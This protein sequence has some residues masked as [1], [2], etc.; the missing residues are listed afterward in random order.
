VNFVDRLQGQA[1]LYRGD[2]AGRVGLCVRV[3][4]GDWR[5]RMPAHRCVAP[6]THAQW[7]PMP[8][9]ESLVDLSA[10][11]LELPDPGLAVMLYGSRARGDSTRDSDVDLLQLVQT[12]TDHYRI[13]RISVA[14]YTQAELE[15][16]CQNGSLFALHLVMEGRIM[17]DPE[18]RLSDALGRYR[19]PDTYDGIWSELRSMTQIVG[20]DPAFLPADPL[21]V[22]RLALYLVR[23]AAILTKIERDGQACFSTLRLAE[24]LDMPELPDLFRGREDPSNLDWH[25]LELGCAALERLLGVRPTNRYGSLEAL[26]VNIEPQSKLVA[27]ACLRILGGGTTVGYGD[28]LLD[29]GTPACE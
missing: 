17:S 23:T 24:E 6:K 26:A 29:L 4:E 11:L 15:L 7:V 22:V 1:D 3:G 16:L 9:P 27:H 12:K 14:A 13:G 19:P 20:T 21:G 2:G 5:F 8:K 28:L 10:L 25:R 18:R